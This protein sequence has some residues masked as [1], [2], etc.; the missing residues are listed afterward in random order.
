VARTR[1]RRLIFVFHAQSGPVAALVDSM[2]KVLMIKGCTLCS[3]THG[4]AGEK[5]EWKTCKESLGVPVEYLHL[6]D[7]PPHL[8]AVVGED[9]PCVIA[10][11]G[12]RFVRLLG[13]DELDR[14]R[15]SVGDF[16]GRLSYHAIG[17]ELELP[18]S[19]GA[20]TASEGS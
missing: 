4:L 8:R 10:E 20:Q 13:P 2:K 1:I 18:L 6:D 17:Q 15:G 9:T 16:R 12:D 19:P 7:I 11:A 14:C 3:I 5:A